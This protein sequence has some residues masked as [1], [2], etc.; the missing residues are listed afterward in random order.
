[1]LILSRKA[2]QAIVIGD[3]IRIVVVAVEG[4]GVRLGIEAPPDV[5]VHRAEVSDDIARAGR[6]ERPPGAPD[7]A[8]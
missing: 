3:A 4:G 7:P 2:G 8:P 5:S 1:M 6:R